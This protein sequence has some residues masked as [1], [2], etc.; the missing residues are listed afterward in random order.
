LLLV[1]TPQ[2]PDWVPEAISSIRNDGEYVDIA[3]P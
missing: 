2:V 1:V 3:N